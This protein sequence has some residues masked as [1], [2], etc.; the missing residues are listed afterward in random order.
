M[1]ARRGSDGVAVTV[2]R[3]T[4]ADARPYQTIR[5]EALEAA[6]AAFAASPE[7]D[8]ARSADFVVRSLSDP[9]QAVFGAFAPDIV[10]MVGV[11]RD[12][13]VKAAHIC[14][15]FGLYVAREHRSSG[16]GR[17]LVTAALEFA[18]SRPGVSQVH[19]GVTDRA[20]EAAALY[21]DLGF[22]AWG[23]EPDALR[24]AG[25]SIAETHLILALREPGVD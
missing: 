18:R 22:A 8:L 16:V 10:G 25:E 2:R 3:L 13:H 15:L 9:E 6:P 12:R 24:V 21:R 23:V 1:A 14:H 20:P 19:A 11:Y 17:R 4:T 5:E 7:D